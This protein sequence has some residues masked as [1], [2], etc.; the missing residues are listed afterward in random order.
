MSR[1]TN[2]SEKTVKTLFKEGPTAVVKK[3]RHKIYEKITG[4]YTRYAY[5]DILFINGCM[6]PHPQ[7]YRVDHQIEQME[8]FGM[9]A[10]SVP[11]DK[12]ELEQVKFYRGFVFYRCP[13]T[14]TIEE[15]IKLAKYYNKQ[16]FFDVDDLVIDTKYTDQVKYVSEMSENDKKLYDD[17]VLRMKKTLELCDYAVTTTERLGKELAK[18]LPEVYINRNVASEK[19]LALSNKACSE[20][21]RS[22][23]KIILGYFS[24]SITHND[25]FELL[26]PVIDELM[27]KYSNVYLK[28]IGIL[29][30]PKELEKHKNRIIAEPFMDWKE[31]PRVIAS[32]DINLAPLEESIFNEAKSENKWLE[33]ALVKVPTIA[34][35]LGAFKEVIEDGVDGILC[36]NRK[37]WREKLEFLIR[38]AQERKHIGEKAHACVVK[39][40]VTTYS[41]KGIV[42]FISSKLK[43]NVGF[44]VP[45]TNISGGVNVV[46]KHASLLQKN[47]CDVFLIS[48]DIVPDDIETID[49]RIPVLIEKY[50]R[51]EGFIDTLIATLWTTLAFVKT[52]S[53][54]LERAYLVQ[55]FETDF[56]KDGRYLKILANAT[57]NNRIRLHYITI[58][59]W[60]QKW[61]KES[62]SQEAGYAPNGIDLSLFTF[63][64]RDFNKRVRILIE[65]NCQDQKKNVD[66]SFKIVNKLDLDKFEIVYLSYGSQVKDWYHIDKCLNKV[67][68]SKVGRVYQECDILLKSSVLESFSYPPLEMMATGGINVVVQNDG[69]REYLQDEYNC[70]FYK[71]GDIE[72]AVEKIN[73]VLHDKELRDKL[74]V[75][76]VKTAEKRSWENAKKDIVAL[77][78]WQ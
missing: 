75:N 57:Y 63:K 51:F 5:K 6:L 56:A 12:L 54:V 26:I 39:K 14:D 65:G 28:I 19:M 60:C 23:E 17:G 8:A 7:R 49:G 69:N 77:Y 48:E 16:I 43:R 29:D 52:C 10:F 55:G 4:D 64:K 30:F 72:D 37:E 53:N 46:L 45:T 13:I 11:Y 1:I 70:V 18:Y 32:V 9:T 73:H 76:G 36:D 68:H 25:D 38:N 31:L 3:A 27:A 2:L 20:R 74:I 58:S 22:D 67:P 61:L 71:Q 62:F 66:E 78:Q 59:K 41:G 33:A 40:Y 47:G 15:F 50:T 34:S 42:D 24:G 44:V 35:N 21:E